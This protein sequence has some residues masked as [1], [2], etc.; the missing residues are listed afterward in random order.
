MQ[1]NNS[2]VIQN[3]YLMMKSLI[4]PNLKINIKMSEY[5]SKMALM[6]AIEEGDLGRAEELLI[7]RKKDYNRVLLTLGQGDLSRAEQLLKN[8]VKVNFRDEDGLTTPLIEASRKD[9]VDMVYLLLNYGADPNFANRLG[10]LPLM[11]AV[12]RLNVD[13]INLLLE[14][15]AV[16]NY[17]DN[18]GNTV[19]TELL[20]N[21]DD[22]ATVRAI[23]EILLEHGLN[24]NLV[25]NHYETA[26]IHTIKE[27]EYDIDAV[28]ILLEYD[29]DPDYISLYDDTALIYVVKS[30]PT[31][32]DM[33]DL[34]LEYGA[35]VDIINK[36]HYTA[37][38]IAAK[39]AKD[40]IVQKL[41]DSGKIA[42]NDGNRGLGLAIGEGY[43]ST[44]EL[45]KSY[46]PK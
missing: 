32:S 34:L 37:F 36:K 15:D 3:V 14:N 2:N 38:M 11:I 42:V 44:I 17:Y 25:N 12:R 23:L 24:I 1:I 10:E 29:A 30:N 7:S 19:L 16:V 40:D 31:N 43:E 5:E 27:I 9:D 20:Q 33:I 21:K 46:L 13:I 18:Y 28:R 41:L 6:E 45:I 8:N 22:N 39:Y 4:F 35:N 26:L